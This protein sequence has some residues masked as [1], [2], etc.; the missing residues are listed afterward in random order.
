MLIVR[1]RPAPA[2]QNM[3]QPAPTGADVSAGAV[4]DCDAGRCVLAIPGA[5]V[6]AAHAETASDMPPSSAPAVAARNRRDAGESV[7]RMTFPLAFPVGKAR[8]SRW[9]TGCAQLVTFAQLLPE[10]RTRAT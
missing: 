2:G 1:V 5:A 3:P 9:I 7:E 10:S 8:K 6:L 4:L